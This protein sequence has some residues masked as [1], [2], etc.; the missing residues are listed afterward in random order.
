MMKDPPVLQEAP[1]TDCGSIVE[2]FTD[3]S[4]WAGIRQAIDRISSNAAV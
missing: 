3:I 1:L 2:I 4:V